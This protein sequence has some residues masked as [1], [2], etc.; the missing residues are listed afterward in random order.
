MKGPDGKKTSEYTSWDNMRRRIKFD[1]RYVNLEHY[2]GWNSF[3][4]F[5]SDMGPRPSLGHSIDRI[6]NSKGYYPW[7][8]R[9]A[10]R[11]EQSRNRSNTLS[12]THDGKTQCLTDWAKELQICDETVRNRLKKGWPVSLALTKKPKMKK[13]FITFRGRTESIRYWARKFGLGAS[14]IAA[15]LDFQHLSVEEALTRKA[16]GGGS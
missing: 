9:W 1:P 12:L 15:R 16:K 11:A 2:T 5:L 13:R 10:T 14:T 8:C 7:N 4:Q 3:D 6:D